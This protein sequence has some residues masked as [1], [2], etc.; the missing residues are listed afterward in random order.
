MWTGGIIKQAAKVQQAR[1]DFYD[2][3]KNQI[4]DALNGSYE[5]L[6][7]II[8]QMVENATVRICWLSDEKHDIDNYVEGLGLENLSGLTKIDMDTSVSVSGYIVVCELRDKNRITVV[9]LIKASWDTTIM[10]GISMLP[11]MNEIAQS[12]KEPV[13]MFLIGRPL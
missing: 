1:F 2:Y 3:D 10:T 13:A 11:Y 6:L 8:S 5:G 4:I 12:N 7:K 9:N